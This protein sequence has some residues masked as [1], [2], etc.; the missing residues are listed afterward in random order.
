V[1]WTRPDDL[2]FNPTGPLP[3]LSDRFRSGPNVLYADGS[4]RSL[5]RDT[6]EKTI[7]AL[8]TRNGGELVTPP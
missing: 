8:L 2:P 5:P 6:P 4:V 1:P 3:P 7:K